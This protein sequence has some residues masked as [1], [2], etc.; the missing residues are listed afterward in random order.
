MTT[1]RT[2]KSRW[3]FALW[4]LTIVSL[5]LVLIFALAYWSLDALEW[6]GLQERNGKPVQ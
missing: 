1:D 5:S 6:G 2:A 3:L 4:Q